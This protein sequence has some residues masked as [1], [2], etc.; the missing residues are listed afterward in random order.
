MT[1]VLKQND[2][3]IQLT[4]WIWTIHGKNKPDCFILLHV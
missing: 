4:N 1:E 3:Y 2:N